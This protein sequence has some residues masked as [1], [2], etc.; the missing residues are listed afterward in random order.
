MGKT[1]ED[2][3]KSHDAAIKSIS[4]HRVDGFVDYLTHVIEKD[5][6]ILVCGNGGS[7]ADAQH[8]VAELVVRFEKTR[9]PIRA[10]A[11]STDTSVI[12]ALGNDMGYE[13]IFERQVHA[14]GRS[15]DLLLC[16][17]SSGESM[18][19]VNA[20]YAGK[21]KGMKVLSIVGNG[22]S[23]TAEISHS[24]IVID[25]NTARVQEGTML[26]LHYL[27]MVAEEFVQG[28]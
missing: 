21:F 22:M 9:M 14:L 11:L 4:P 1:F 15:G 2:I 28:M 20:V 27:A 26:I 5:R 16:L 19:V 23:R 25:G 12:T 3:C 7:A 24:S 17:S 13:H 8:F 6:N 10:V 18:N